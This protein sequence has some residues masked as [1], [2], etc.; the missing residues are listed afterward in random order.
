MRQVVELLQIDEQKARPL[1]NSKLHP[2]Y[3]MV[4]ANTS[5]PVR[6]FLFFF[7]ELDEYLNNSGAR[8]LG[9]EGGGIV[10]DSRACKQTP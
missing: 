3:A 9:Y 8:T 7:Q 6:S 1:F 2:K 4:V 5:N 10:K